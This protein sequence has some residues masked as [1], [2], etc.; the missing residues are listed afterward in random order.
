VNKYL[1]RMVCVLLIFACIVLV[2]VYFL[3]YNPY[4]RDVRTVVTT[5]TST[6]L[7]TATTWSTATMT[8][9]STLST[10]MMTMYSGGLETTRY[11]LLQLSRPTT[12]TSGYSIGDTVTITVAAGLDRNCDG[13]DIYVYGADDRIEGRYTMVPVQSLPQSFQHRFTQA[14][15]HR[16]LLWATH[17]N[18]SRF[19]FLDDIVYVY[20]T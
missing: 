16:I 9:Y 8:V 20:V 12:L 11:L 7:V 19:A 1:V 5:I 15:F 17:W 2:P 18:R 3:L 4:E 13:I 6:K 14:G 10:D